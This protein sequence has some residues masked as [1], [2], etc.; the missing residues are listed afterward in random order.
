MMGPY[1]SIYYGCF[2]PIVDFYGHD[3]HI[4]FFLVVFI[5]W[6][7]FMV[8]MGPDID[9]YWT[10]SQEPSGVEAVLVLHIN[11]CPQRHRRNDRGG[12]CARH[13]KNDWLKGEIRCLFG[14]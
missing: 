4:S 3:V 14:T 9:R 5:Q 8:M 11:N 6:L 13:G 10:M 1:I 7:I 12:R 2:Y